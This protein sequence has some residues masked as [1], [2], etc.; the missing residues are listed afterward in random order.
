MGHLQ[1]VYDEYRDRGVAMIG[2]N[3]VDVRE[4]AQAY[5][6][7]LGI[8]FP[9]IIDAPEEIGTVRRKYETLE[10][11]NAVPLSY[12]IDREGRAVD[13][14]Y[15]ST[16]NAVHVIEQCLAGAAGGRLQVRLEGFD[17]AQRNLRVLLQ[18]DREGHFRY[19][20]RSLRG[21][22]SY[23]ESRPLKAGRWV[24]SLV[25]GDWDY[26]VRRLEIQPGKTARVTISSKEA[27]ISGRKKDVKGRL[28]FPDKEPLAGYKVQFFAFHSPGIDEDDRSRTVFTDGEGGFLMK[29]L[30]PGHW[31]VFAIRDDHPG[32]AITGFKDL[33]IDGDATS[34]V[35]LDLTFHR[36]RVTGTLC[37]AST[38]E[39]LGEDDGQ[40]WIFLVDLDKG[41]NA[42]E[43]QNGH[44]G[45]RF[46]L[47][48]VPPGRYR[49]DVMVPG[50]FDTY[51]S[52][53]FL[54]EAGEEID[55]GRIQL[56]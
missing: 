20:P 13:A 21:D 52:D 29:G 45:S 44:R 54:V 32:E 50:V 8:T 25:F 6:E 19:Q 28:R 55:L 40:W 22:G 24:L 51:R 46:D 9:N 17:P 39:P 38:G 33:F 41:W 18:E 5:M 2:L 23:E 49:L 26:A 48:G 37:R 34:P 35:A 15:G 14:W 31:W 27:S 3:D 16:Y 10:G 11:M 4:I 42:C 12:V 30:L 47:P 1:R 43:L 7:K 36:G 53:E 56:K